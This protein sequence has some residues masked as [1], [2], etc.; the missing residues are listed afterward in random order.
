M[1]WTTNKEPFG[2]DS[3]RALIFLLIQGHAFE[4]VGYGSDAL[5]CAGT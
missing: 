1:T 5:A 2:I 4:L 3:W